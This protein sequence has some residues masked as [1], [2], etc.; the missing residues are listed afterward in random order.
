MPLSILG[1]AFASGDADGISTTVAVFCHELPH[2]LG[3]YCTLPLSNNCTVIPL[4]DFIH[5]FFDN[6]II[7]WHI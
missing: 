7:Y 1:A 4:C 5:L 3:K 2:E 6:L